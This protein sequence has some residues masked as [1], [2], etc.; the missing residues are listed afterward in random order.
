MIFTIVVSTWQ[1][2]DLSR[3]RNKPAV[4]ERHELRLQLRLM[5]IYELQ[6]YTDLS[7]DLSMCQFTFS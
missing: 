1:L 3:V 5:L 6:V 7:I 4:R 2:H